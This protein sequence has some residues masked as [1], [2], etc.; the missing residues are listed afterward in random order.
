MD[1]GE[2]LVILDARTFDE[3][4]T[5][6]IPGGIST[7]G[8]EL[9]LRAR[10]TAPSAKTTII[11]N[12]AGRTRSLIGAQSL[13]NARIPNKVFAL[14]NGTIGWT[15]EGFDLA[16]GS[17]R[18]S[19]DAPR[20]IADEALVA[21]R[22]VSYAAGARR[23]DWQDLEVLSAHA[24]RSVYKFDV[25]TRGEHQIN[26][27]PGFVW[28]EGGQLVQET[29]VYAPIRGARIVLCDDVGPRAHMTA[30]WLAQMAWDVY[31]LEGEWPERQPGQEVQ[32][33][34]HPPDTA[35]IEPAKLAQLLEEQS[36][37]LIDL[38]SSRVF[39]R[40]RIPGATFAIR[41]RLLMMLST[42][43]T[44]VPLVLTSP[45]GSLAQWTAVE[46]AE[47]FAGSVLVLKGG[48]QGW[49]KAGLPLV[50]VDADDAYQRPYVSASSSR[51]AMQAYLDWEA[52]LVAQL[53]KDA[54]HGF[55]VI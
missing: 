31:V 25:R 38:A 2:D 3:Y 14:R 29:D 21:A 49:L 41:S 8:A 22:A 17:D 30:S 54:T 53:E 7:P 47:A 28:A 12:C 39:R 45:D 4:Q 52:G 1:R 36:V 35:M 6:A 27:P 26:H 5:M 43:P 10:T 40:Q 34:P 46:A 44:Q 16:F 24:E 19:G 50:E 18:R 32:P 9:V 13:I 48:T 11:V 37:T 23:I 51:L 33:R 55:F 20:S 42:L 15:L